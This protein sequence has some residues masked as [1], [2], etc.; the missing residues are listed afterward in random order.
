MAETALATISLRAASFATIALAGFHFA[1]P[2]VFAWAQ[3]TAQLPAEIRWALFAMNT[4]LS[5]LLLLGGLVT[6]VDSG[7]RRASS[8]W[9][10]RAMAVFWVFNAAY[11]TVRPF[12]TPVLRWV[13]LA[14][15][16][17]VAALYLFPL[18]AAPQPKPWPSAS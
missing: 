11:Q 10:I 5:L 14:F 12:P 8:L 7:K 1:L 13:S 17:I 2:R 15:A 18:A 3:F 16:L 4:F 6:L 9:P